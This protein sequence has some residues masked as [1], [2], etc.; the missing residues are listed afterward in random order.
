MKKIVKLSLAVLASS[1]LLV[2]CQ[3]G[4]APAESETT[5]ESPDTYYM[6]SFYVDDALYKTARVKA[7]EKVDVTID[8]PKQ[9]GYTFVGWATSDGKIFD[10]TSDI[11]TGKTDLYARFEKNQVSVPETTDPYLDE[12]QL[13]VDD[14]KDALKNYYLVIGWWSNDKSGITDEI[15]KHFYANVNRFLRI[16]GA[17]NSDLAN[18]S[19]RKFSQAK[20]AD[21]GAAMNEQGDLDIVIGV[22]NNINSSAGVSI[23]EKKGGFTYGKITGRYAA[24]LTNNEV[25]VALYSFLI[26]DNGK[27]MADSSYTLVESDI[28]ATPSTPDTSE[29]ST[30]EPSSSEPTTPDSSESSSA[31][32]SEPDSSEPSSSSEGSRPTPGPGVFTP[33]AELNVID[34]KEEGKTYYLV[35]GWYAK[36]AT[37][38]LDDALMKHFVWNMNVYL[39]SIGASTEDLGNISIRKFEQSTVADMGAAMNEQGDL[40][41]VI[42]VGN[43]IN[44]SAGVSIKEKQDGIKMGGKSR[45]I[46]RLTDRPIVNILY[47]FMKTEQGKTMY[48]TNVTFTTSTFQ[49]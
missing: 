32:S 44:S 18:V 49:E 31:G 36:T 42:G 2:G 37:S 23:Q 27:K 16:K 17:Q 3:N 1:M 34:T 5:S 40:D 24:R 43:N 41:I 25:A 47:E 7:G 21:M 30:S 11:V 22:G 13:N 45:Y 39:D 6:V 15:A 14:T 12:S 20:V 8:E 28:P 35:V 10:L 46:A 33:E 9:D 4:D 38:G 19:F 26:T 48:D 29:P